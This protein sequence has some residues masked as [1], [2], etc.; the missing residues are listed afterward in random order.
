MSTVSRHLSD[1]RKHLAAPLV[2]LLAACSAGPADE[3]EPPVAVAAITVGDRP[4][5]AG[6]ASAT[7]FSA[8]I[9]R[10]REATLS[11][12]V[13][14]RITAMTARPGMRLGAGALVAAVDA[15]P[16]AAG[17]ARQAAEVDRLARAATRY[18]ALVPE[19][20]VAEAQ[21]KDARNALAAARAA[22]A[23]ARYDAASAKLT[24]PFAGVV[25]SRQSETGE[26]VSPGQAVAMVA[27]LNAPLVATA[28]VPAGFAARLRAGMPAQV[29]VEGAPAPLA[30]RV[31]RV[32][33]GA[34]ARSGTVA[35]D[36]ALSG[37]PPALASGTTASARF[38]L[39]A[40]A[41]AGD[42]ST[43]IPAEALLEAKGDSGY[44]YAIDAKGYAR[45]RQ[46]RFLGF[47]DQSARIAGIA[48]GTKLITAGAGFVTDGQAVTV[49]RQ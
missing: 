48:P 11:F 8:T 37:A 36:L 25:L 34:D 35:V 6:E 14:G 16:Y 33:G 2:V 15:T 45:K 20:A 47:D 21:A 26:T 27:D 23:A 42:G 17:V 5:L 19:G 4:A 32:A 10:D 12:R 39:P 44:V 30:A 22:L 49:A 13:G 28:Q 7:G 29:Q 38:S 41:A 18:D 3:P 46:V 9:H 31:L 43:L 40:A 24:M 1:A